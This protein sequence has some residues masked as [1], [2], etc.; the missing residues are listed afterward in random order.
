MRFAVRPYKL[1]LG[2]NSPPTHLHTMDNK[3]QTNLNNYFSCSNT[4]PSVC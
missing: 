2:Y 1:N 4:Q 3:N